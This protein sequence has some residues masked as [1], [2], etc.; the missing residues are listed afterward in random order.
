VCVCVCV[1]VLCVCKCPRARA[2]T[3]SRE[4]RMIENGNSKSRQLPKQS[5]HI[6]FLSVPFPPSTYTHV[7]TCPRAHTL[8]QARKNTHTKC[9]H[10]HTRTHTRA[11]AAVTSTIVEKSWPCCSHLELLTRMLTRLQIC[12]QIY[13]HA[14]TLTLNTPAHLLLHLAHLH[15]HTRAHLHTLAHL[16]TCT[17]EHTSTQT[18]VNHPPCMPRHALAG[19]TAA[20]KGTAPVQLAGMAPVEQRSSPTKTRWQQWNSLPCVAVAD[21]L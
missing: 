18:P 17:R 9:I 2:C 19:R 7:H 15:V 11:N 16:H 10:T 21:T 14:L 20:G 1:C 12:T 6:F 13:F 3:H 4:W 8:I 5:M